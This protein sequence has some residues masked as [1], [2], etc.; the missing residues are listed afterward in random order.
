VDTSV[1][2]RPDCER[3]AYRALPQE[4]LLTSLNASRDG[5]S[6]SD[7]ASRL[8]AIGPNLLNHAVGHPSLRAGP[9]A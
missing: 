6:A 8:K 1:G 4:A 3:G 5:L 9:R 2:I 7:A